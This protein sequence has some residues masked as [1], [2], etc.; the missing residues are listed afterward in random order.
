VKA[1]EAHTIGQ[2]LVSGTDTAGTVE[3]ADALGELIIGASVW[4]AVAD[5]NSPVVL[6]IA[7]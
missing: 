6:R 1:D 5:E 2:A 4:T 3:T 7:P